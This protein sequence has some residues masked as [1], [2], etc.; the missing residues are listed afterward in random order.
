[1]PP[2]MPTGAGLLQGAGDDRAELPAFPP[3]PPETDRDPVPGKG[4]SLD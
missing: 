2:I 1:M 4:L 3:L